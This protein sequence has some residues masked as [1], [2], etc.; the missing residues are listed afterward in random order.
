MQNA[1]CKMQNCGRGEI[2]TNKQFINRKGSWD[3]NP[4]LQIIN[5][6]RHCVTPFLSENRHPFV[7]YATFPLTGEF[8]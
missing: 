3:E 5:L 6:I 7:A 2:S 1:K 4:T 8:P